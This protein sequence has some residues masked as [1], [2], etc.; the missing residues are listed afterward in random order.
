M[1]QIDGNIVYKNLIIIIFVHLKIC[2]SSEWGRI[3]LGL[4][5]LRSLLGIWTCYYYYKK[6]LL[7]LIQKFF[8]AFFFLLERPQYIV[9]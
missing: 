6:K 9:K 5:S 3:D 1:V 8:L 2:L 7:I 4:F